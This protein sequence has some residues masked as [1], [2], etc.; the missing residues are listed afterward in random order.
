MDRSSSKHPKITSALRRQII[1]GTM[2]PGHRLP[3][4]VALERQFGAST[5]TIQKALDRLSRDGFVS[6][7][8]RRGTFVADH[9][10]HLSR[11]AVVFYTNPAEFYWGGCWDAL[12]D[13]AGEIER[14]SPRE[15]PCFYDIDGHPDREDF[16]RL[17]SDVHAH[18]FAGIIFSTPTHSLERTALFEHRDLPCVVLSAPGGARDMPVIVYDRNSFHDKAFDHFRRRGRRAVAVLAKSGT[19]SSTYRRDLIGEM[20][21]RGVVHRAH[22]L[23]V[24]DAYDP[25]SAMSAVHALFHAGQH[26]RPDALLITDDTFLEGA[27]AGLVA[28][29]VRVPDDVEVVALC[30]FSSRPVRSPLLVTRLGFDARE[31]M[32]KAI[33]CIDLQRRGHRPSP[34]TYVPARFEEELKTNFVTSNVQLSQV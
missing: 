16:Q 33:E 10:P 29:G 27:V 19:E 30:N 3:N 14:S 23:Q 20:P 2:Q 11:Y 26:E 15:M 17:L 21:A 28:A 4:R 1:E 25:D 6:S 32:Q 5:V 9:P 22:W 31:T 13:V 34:L 18:R 12:R 24:A 7:H 8:R